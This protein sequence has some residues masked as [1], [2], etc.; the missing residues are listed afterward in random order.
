MAIP[1]EASEHLYGPL[2]SIIFGNEPPRSVHFSFT[3][4]KLNLHVAQLPVNYLP[5]CGVV[6]GYF[7]RTL[8]YVQQICGSCKRN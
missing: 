1:L 7:M 6:N 4:P 2:N 3:V 8:W 5:L